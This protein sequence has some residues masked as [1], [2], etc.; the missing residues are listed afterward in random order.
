M[1]IR[2]EAKLRPVICA[3]VPISNDF[4]LVR[5]VHSRGACEYRFQPAGCVHRRPRFRAR[6]RGSSRAAMPE[7]LCSRPGP[8][9]C[10]PLAQ[11][12]RTPGRRRRQTRIPNRGRPKRAHPI[13]SL[14]EIQRPNRGATRAQTDSRARRYRMREPSRGAAAGAPAHP[15]V[16]RYQTRGPSRGAARAPTLRMARRRSRIRPHS[17]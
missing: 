17:S 6:L 15:R 5:G 10:D 2:P 16:Q 9:R 13:P 3:R 4:L 14:R 7:N 12:C 11:R 1:R 8:V